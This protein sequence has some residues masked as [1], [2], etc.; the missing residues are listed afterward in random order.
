MKVNE[1]DLR[2]DMPKMQYLLIWHVFLEKT[3]IFIYN[4]VDF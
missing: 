1:L 4:I 2:E 3:G